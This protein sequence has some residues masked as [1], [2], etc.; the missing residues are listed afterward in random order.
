MNW[1]LLLK[2]AYY[3]FLIGIS[4]RVIYD[5][6][7]SV[8][9]SA[10]ILLIFILP[11]L[12]V[13]IYL[14][15]GLNYRKS[16][17]YDKKLLLDDKQ[18]DR[19]SE[20]IQFYLKKSKGAFKSRYNN[21]YGLSQMLFSD[22][23]CLPTRNNKVKLLENGE[24]KFVYLLDA[25]KNA[26]HHIHME[27][28][29]YEN[30]EIGNEIA[31]ILMQKAKE[32]VEVR[33]IYD[34]FGSNR[35]RKNLVKKMRK[36]GV[37]AFAFYKVIFIYLANRLNYR[38]HRKIVIID[39][40]KA[41][42][43]GINVSDKYIN[44]QITKNYWRDTHLMIEG[45]AV[46]ELQ[47]IFLADWNFCANQ[48]VKP[49]AEFFK[50]HTR[51]EAGQWVQVVS[52]GPDSKNPSILYS[53]LQAIAVAKKEV[54][55]TTP[56]LIPSE[57]F[58]QALHMAALRGVDVRILVPEKSDSIFVNSVSKSYFRDLLS[59]GIKIYL[60]QKGFVHAKT[61]VCDE[62][63][64][65]VGTANIDNRSFDLNF[66]VNALV[67]DEDFATELKTLF[68]KDLSDAKELELAEWSKRRKSIQ[69]LEKAIRVFSPLL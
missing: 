19:I 17:I 5:T 64:A 23:K 20:I 37:E 54:Y 1:D 45:E 59:K 69:I 39:G 25:L 51:L 30:D 10:Y 49:R 6:K 14:S 28:Y 67:Y 8:K 13:L 38:N 48:E 60:Y 58:I 65:V 3:L 57:D 33:F 12:G 40:E 50:E 46:W 36:N 56:Y 27:Y 52:S 32:G 66:E 44:K 35:I 7:S 9:A 55:I 2:L 26:K 43:G 15:F 11:I 42:V 22:N 29:I 4:I 34:D 47:R 61:M 41:F 63:L 21:F 62:Q 24:Q 53:F 16:G 18:A 31:K 68:F